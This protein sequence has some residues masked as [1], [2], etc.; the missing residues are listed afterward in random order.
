MPGAGVRLTVNAMGHTYSAAPQGR[1]LNHPFRPA[2]SGGTV[3][4]VLGIVDVFV[5]LIGDAP[6]VDQVTLVQAPLTIDSG[7]AV[8]DEHGGLV[9]WVMLEVSPN[10]D[11]VL[12]VKS[13]IE[14]KHSGDPSPSHDIALGRQAITQLLWRGTQCIQ[15][16]PIVRFHLR[17]QR[18]LP[19][20]AGG[21]VK[22]FFL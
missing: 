8:K 10:A 5:P 16:I 21:V 1:S 9:S 13:K 2:L 11:G 20:P 4:F 12:D 22:H 18:V 14:L 17:Y 3:R 15:A 6:M 19:P 7:V